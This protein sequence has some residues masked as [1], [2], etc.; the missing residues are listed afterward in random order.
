M[1]DERID[2]TSEV[3]EG[4]KSDNI[5]S[6]ERIN[7]LGNSL[8]IL[9]GIASPARAEKILTWIEDEC[10]GMR[11]NGELSIDLSPNLFPFIKP[12]DL[13]GMCDIQHITIRENTIMEAFGLL[14]AGFM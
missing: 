11:K 10:S 4:A 12:E 14:S 7:L 1:V 13:T 5:Y 2:F 3:V 8:A 9:S 6:S